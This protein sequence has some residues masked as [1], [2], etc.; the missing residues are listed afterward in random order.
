[1]MVCNSRR[2][3][4]VSNGVWVAGLHPLPLRLGKA[5]PSSK[6]SE[7]FRKVK[8]HEAVSTTACDP[9]LL[10]NGIQVDSGGAFSLIRELA[11]RNSPSRR[12]ISDIIDAPHAES[13][14]P[15]A[16]DDPT[17]RRIDPQLM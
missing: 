12:S 10:V 17:F 4:H 15:A 13:P 16:I 11:D 3:R 7:Y 8:G 1:M 9:E 5:L 14:A 2:A 6:R